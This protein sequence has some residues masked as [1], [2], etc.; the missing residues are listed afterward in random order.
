[1]CR[2][3]QFNMRI[4]DIFI[5]AFSLWNLCDVAN[6]GNAD[7]GD[8]GAFAGKILSST[9]SSQSWDYSIF[10]KFAMII[11]YCI[12]WRI[13]SARKPPSSACPSSKWSSKYNTCCCH[14]DCCW[15]SCR[16]S[17]LPTNCWHGD[18]DIYWRRGSKG[19]AWVAQLCKI[20]ISD[21]VFIEIFDDI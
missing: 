16:T 7:Y 1:M 9:L 3:S 13:V 17:Y 11:I 20:H 15:D 12:N 4:I 5:S 14:T 2:C 6:G 8:Y 18:A 10:L 19:G 21:T